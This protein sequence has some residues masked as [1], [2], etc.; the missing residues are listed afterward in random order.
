GALARMGALADLALECH[1]VGALQSNRCREVATRFDWV[2]S[3]DRPRLVEALARSRPDGMPPLDVLVQ[4]NVEG[5]AGKGG[6]AP[7]D[8]A[9]LAAAIAARPNLR[10]RGLMA[11]PMPAG[12]AQRRQAFA[13]VRGLFEDLRRRHDI[14][15]LSMGMSDD[16]EAAIAEG[17][18]MV[19][20]GTALFG[21]RS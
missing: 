2:Q 6:C 16:F 9:S 7:S 5:E 14:D 12:M 3:V 15:T 18:T 10:L 19:R 8:V 17:A 4:V 20:I 11:I 1:F 21:P 13:A